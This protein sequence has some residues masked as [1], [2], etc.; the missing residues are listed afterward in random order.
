[1]DLSGAGGKDTI[2]ESYEEKE[3][4]YVCVCPPIVWE[5]GMMCDC[6]VWVRGDR[7]GGSGV[8]VG[9]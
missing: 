1:M 4:V 3:C 7:D 9:A 2:A 6:G 5:V 8:R